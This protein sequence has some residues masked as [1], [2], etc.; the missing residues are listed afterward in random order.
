MCL[1][2]PTTWMDHYGHKPFKNIATYLYHSR[3]GN[4]EM[5]QTGI[6]KTKRKSHLDIHYIIDDQIEEQEENFD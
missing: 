4:T 5:S 1:L 2:N 6:E 3:A